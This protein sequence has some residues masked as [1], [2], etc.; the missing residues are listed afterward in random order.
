MLYIMID[1]LGVYNMSVELLTKPRP[2]R[3]HK[4]KKK[5]ITFEQFCGLIQETDKADL[6]EGV[7]Y[8]QSPPS[9]R[10]EFIFCIR[11]WF[12]ASGCV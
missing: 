11:S 12:P 5:L 10:H 8:M 3:R 1:I 6:I 9:R 2:H 7:I 4:A